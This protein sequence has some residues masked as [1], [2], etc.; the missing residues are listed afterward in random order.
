MLP[1]TGKSSKYLQRRK[2]N[3]LRTSTSRDYVET[4]LE[5]IDYPELDLKSPTLRSF[6]EL[7]I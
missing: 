4:I 7:E 3:L 6:F 2:R 1:I 5:N